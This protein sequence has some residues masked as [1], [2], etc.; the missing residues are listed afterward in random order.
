VLINCVIRFGK[1][2]IIQKLPTY[3]VLTFL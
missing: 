1:D 2:K 3:L